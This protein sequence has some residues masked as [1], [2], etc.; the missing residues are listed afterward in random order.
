MDTVK[1]M[2][3]A[4]IGILMSLVLKDQKQYL[5]IT[6]AIIC[7]VCLFFMMLPY[8]ESVVSYVKILNSSLNGDILRTIL[9]ITGIGTLSTLTS[10][11]CRDAGFS[12]IASIVVISG[13]AICMCVVLPVIGSFLGEII[14]ILP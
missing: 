11:I 5:G 4:I 7:T 10:N 8:L 6:V 13:K 2:A 9:K 12:A 14:S 3:V 1:I